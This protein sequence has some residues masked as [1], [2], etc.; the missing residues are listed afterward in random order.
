MAFLQRHLKRMLAFSTI[1]HAGMMLVGFALLDSKALAGTALLVL[2]HGLLKGGLFLVCGLVLIQLR[3]I[4]ELR[5]HGAGRR[6]RWSAALWFL[7]SVGLIG[8]PYVGSFLGHSLIED[9]ATVVGIEWVQPFL[10]VGAGLASAALLRAG[11][12]VFLGWGP[13]EDPMLSPQ[14]PESPSERD[15]ALPLM[16]A[17][18]TVAIV[19]G[20][21]VSVVPGLQTRAEHGAERF[22]DHAA[23]A[24]LV[25]HGKPETPT[26]ALPYTIERATGESWGYGIGS[27]VLALAGAAFGLWWQRLPELGRAAGTRILGPPVH[28]LKAAHSGIVGDYILWIAIG[29]AVLGG[30]WA[31]TLR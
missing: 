19:L 26:P 4:D 9:G 31:F 3:Q 15:A 25:L 12:R 16:G 21:V 20:L 1:S 14:P 28:V 30:V 2:A 13:A 10:M 18:A 5:L 22:R 27:L 29:T 8:I 24:Q 11:A 17:V 6:L 23:Y 7:G